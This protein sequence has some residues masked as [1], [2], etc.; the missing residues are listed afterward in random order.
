MSESDGSISNPPVLAQT[1]QDERPSRSRARLACVYRP[2]RG[3]WA[4]AWQVPETRTQPWAMWGGGSA[5]ALCPAW[6]QSLLPV[7]SFLGTWMLVP[8]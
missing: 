4:P 3:A 7:G 8:C 2:C 5:A 1:A 6:P